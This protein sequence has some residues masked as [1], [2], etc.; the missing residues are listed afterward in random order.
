MIQ[1]YLRN[2]SSL[3]FLHSN[4]NAIHL[5]VC[6]LAEDL[7]ND[8]LYNY[9]NSN[10]RKGISYIIE[11]GMIVKIAYEFQVSLSKKLITRVMLIKTIVNITSFKDDNY[12]A[13][14]Y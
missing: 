2:F 6:S 12:E 4:H 9:F 8:L 14:N 5:S 13:Y 11:F 3:Y 10:N 1:I 7:F